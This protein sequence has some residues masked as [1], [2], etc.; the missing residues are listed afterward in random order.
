MYG[1]MCGYIDKIN[2]QTDRRTDLWIDGWGGWVFGQVDGLI[3]DGQI[4][5]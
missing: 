5:R 1:W 3:V 2:K 4:D